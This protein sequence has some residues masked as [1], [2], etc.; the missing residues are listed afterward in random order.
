MHTYNIKILRILII[1]LDTHKMERDLKKD[2]CL[3]TQIVYEIRT[4]EKF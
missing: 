4:K 3:H 1:K 2:I